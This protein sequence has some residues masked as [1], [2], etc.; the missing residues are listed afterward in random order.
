MSIMYGHL[1]IFVRHFVSFWSYKMTCNIQ[2]LAPPSGFMFPSPPRPAD[3][4][5]IAYCVANIAARQQ[6]TKQS[7]KLR[8]L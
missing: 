7:S 4:L 2:R 5:G 8:K 1:A 3:R 6:L